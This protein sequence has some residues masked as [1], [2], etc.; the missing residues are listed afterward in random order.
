MKSTV[1]LASVLLAAV[2][3]AQAGMKSVCSHGDQT[4]VIEVVYPQGGLVPCDVVYT[5]DNGASVLWS[6]QNESGFCEQKAEAFVQ[7]QRGWGWNCETSM[8][9]IFS[10]RRA[11]TK[12]QPSLQIAMLKWKRQR[13]P[14]P[15]R[16]NNAVNAPDQTM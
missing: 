7:K 10:R 13:K 12:W 1:L 4:R 16:N 5:K 3:A 11:L 9:E 15:Q 14:L 2:P 8:S 6:A